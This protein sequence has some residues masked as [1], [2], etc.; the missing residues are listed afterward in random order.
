[1]FFMFL[2]ILLIKKDKMFLTKKCCSNE[3]VYNVKVNITSAHYPEVFC[4]ICYVQTIV[5][6]ISLHVYKTH[7][8]DLH[9]HT[10]L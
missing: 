10:Y 9:V 1:M 3:E 7:V 6:N 8:N 2:F 5:L 4:T